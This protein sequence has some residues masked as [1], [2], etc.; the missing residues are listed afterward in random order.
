M[1]S[2]TDCG[3]PARFAVS[4]PVSDRG[5]QMQTIEPKVVTTGRTENVS[6]Y[7][8]SRPAIGQLGCLRYGKG[9]EN[10]VAGKRNYTLT[11]SV[12]SGNRTTGTM[13]EPVPGVPKHHSRKA[14]G[15]SIDYIGD[16]SK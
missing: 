1:P 3:C 6:I 15:V 13:L 9:A 11:A 10:G 12:G 16:I 8:V 4:G 5:F 14:V 2:Q 7:E